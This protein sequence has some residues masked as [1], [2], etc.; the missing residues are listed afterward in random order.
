M[1][2]LSVIGIFISFHFSDCNPP[3]GYMTHFY[4]NRRK[5]QVND[6]LVLELTNRFLPDVRKDFLTC[7]IQVETS[8]TRKLLVHFMSLEISDNEDDLDRLHIYDYKKDQKATRISPPQGLYGVYDKY[9]S[10][11]SGGVPSDYVTS[12][13]KLKLDYQGK[14]TLAYDG[15]KILITSFRESRGG[16]GR[17]YFRC[18]R[19]DICI[20]VSTWCDGFNNCGN[21]DHSD[22][23]NCDQ[24]RGNAWKPWDGQVTAVVAASVSCTV[25]L[26]TAGLIVLIIRKMN[27]REAI[28]AHITVEF[29]KKRKPNRKSTNGE[30]LTR[31]YAPPSYEVVVGMDEEPPPYEAVEDDYDT[32][33]DDDNEVLNEHVTMNTKGAC[34]VTPETMGNNKIRITSALVTCDIEGNNVKTKVNKTNED[35]ILNQRKEF[36]ELTNYKL[37]SSAEESSSNS[38]TS[39]NKNAQIQNNHAGDEIEVLESV[40]SDS[41]KDENSNSHN[42]QKLSNG[43]VHTLIG[44]GHVSS[45][46][47][48]GHSKVMFKRSPSTRDADTIEYVDSD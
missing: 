9:Y 12:G 17:G 39:Q 38:S 8:S 18:N 31:L 25:F 21:N 44:N 47:C 35:N 1:I 4:F 5:V 27:K 46:K 37:C 3:H 14:P 41:S 24:N 13:N 19:K 15:F 48:N 22:E 32:E 33:T 28:N 23:S 45:E 16:C 43:T 20:P 2:L 6:S 7:D 34:A 42:Q 26:L 10:K 29:K 11:M 30:L 40:D 36:Q